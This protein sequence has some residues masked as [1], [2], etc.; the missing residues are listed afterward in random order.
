MFFEGHFDQF[1]S[2]L[3]LSQQELDSVAMMF[4]AIPDLAQP[5]RFRS[6]DLNMQVWT[7]PGNA[8]N[9]RIY[10]GT[11]EYHFINMLEHRPHRRALVS[12]LAYDREHRVEYPLALARC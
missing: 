10:A 1:I 2:S 3:K 7:D 6:C 11:G 12:L 5:T 4:W 9:Q 8:A